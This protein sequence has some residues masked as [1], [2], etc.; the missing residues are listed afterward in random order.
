VWLGRERERER[1]S[2]REG[3][4]NTGEFEAKLLG[5]IGV[6]AWEIG[7]L[8]ELKEVLEGTLARDA[9]VHE[10]LQHI[11]RLLLARWSG[12]GRHG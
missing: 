1:E 4:G 3:G 12:R 9:K 8:E 6:E 11:Q 5:D 10:E 7:D 2:E